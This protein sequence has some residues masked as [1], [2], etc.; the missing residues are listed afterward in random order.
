MSTE[1]EG[2]KFRNPGRTTNTTSRPHTIFSSQS[3][4]NLFNKNK[5]T[6]EYS[7]SFDNASHDGGFQYPR[8]LSNTSVNTID[9]VYSANSPHNMLDTHDEIDDSNSSIY[10]STMHK[11][12]SSSKTSSTGGTSAIIKEGY[13]NKKTDTNASSVSSS[14]GRSWR[15][16]YV[17]LR[18][19][20]LIFYKPPTEAEIQSTLAH[21]T[22]KFQASPK[23][24]PASSLA[25]IDDGP[26]NM[27]MFLIPATFDSA[28][29]SFLFEPRLVG[30]SRSQPPLSENYFYGEMFTEVDVRYFKFKR[31]TSLLIFNDSI[32]VFKRRWIHN[33]RSS[34]FDTVNSAF[35]IGSS[36]NTP[37]DKVDPTKGYY[38]KW[39]HHATYPL[40]D[41]DIVDASSTSFNPN[42][43]LPS[44]SQSNKSN[45][46]SHNNS[47]AS[48][49]ATLSS[50]NDYSSQLSA[51]T[52]QAFQ[53]FVRDKQRTTRLFVATNSDS[54]TSWTNKLQDAKDALTKGSQ[55]NAS[56]NDSPKSTN[57]DNV[58]LSPQVNQE[59]RV[60]PEPARVRL[61][62]GLGQHP[63]LV[64]G[65]SDNNVVKGGSTDALIHEAIFT[66]CT[67]KDYR[68]AFLYTYK[69]FT[70]TGYLCQEIGRYTSQLPTFSDDLSSDEIKMHNR[71]I[72]FLL[73]LIQF[74]GPNLSADDLSI[75]SNL[76]ED[77]L[78]PLRMPKI[79]ELTELWTQTHSIQT[80]PMIEVEHDSGEM[81]N[82]LLGLTKTGLTPA[83]FLKLDATDLA[84]QLYLFHYLAYS[85]HY[86]KLSDPCQLLGALPE[87]VR[88]FS[89]TPDQPHFLTK[90]IYH[91][92]FFATPSSSPSRRAA[93]LNHWIQVGLMC[94][95][96]GD[97]ASWIAIA[98]GVCSPVVT[99][100]SETWRSVDKRLTKIVT[101]RWEKCLFHAVWS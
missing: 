76:I 9:C 52:M 88:S 93:L 51:G 91:H 48:S 80:K 86:T 77:K 87:Q 60:V 31:Y 35:K 49:V 66:S 37:P 13:M 38:T 83:F 57:Q 54:L 25:S 92:L 100:L 11:L 3:I 14:L 101:K 71:I 65:T 40:L 62:W 24:T 85:Q 55:K 10:E 78:E 58:P 56:I 18:G 44:G 46:Y 27:G 67:G 32:M 47:S 89:F 23:T 42:S 98:I 16:Y 39:K 15:L 50:S 53:L 61:F 2:V 95:D 70:T 1:K 7:K 75:I 17:T 72:Q 73:D 28:A 45:L 97:M 79:L 5:N 29:R 94:R 68:L 30:P 6:Q 12:T 41:T 22:G 82:Y 64:I 96:H 36:Y 33:N 43:P 74:C 63:E 59:S 20:K 34:I 26:K 99:R 8:K 4:S 81:T 19:A 21:S 90:L 69:L 84:Q